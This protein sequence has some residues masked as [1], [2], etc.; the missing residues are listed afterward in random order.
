MPIIEFNHNKYES[1]EGETV[2]EAL[3][4]QGIPIP[5]G[6]KS[7]ICQGCLMRYDNY[8]PTPVEQNGLSAS[9]RQKN[10]FLSCQCKPKN[11]IQ[12]YEP[13]ESEANQFK[14]VLVDKTLLND[15]VMRLR[16]QANLDYIPGQYVTLWKA[17]DA[18]RNYS[19]ASH[20]DYE[21]LLE[22]HI[23]RISNGAVSYWVFDELETGQSIKFSGP[24]GT[25]VYPVNI[26]EDQHQIKPMLMIAM[27][28]GLA[29]I[30]GVLKDALKHQHNKPI[31]LVVGTTHSNGFYYVDEIHELIKSHSNVKSHFIS[32]EGNSNY[33]TQGNIYDFCK[34]NFPDLKNHWIFVCGKA[35]FVQ[36]MKKQCFLSGAQLSDIYADAFL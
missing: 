34:Q 5:H 29:P 28:T 36:K 12:V 20:P 32:L 16:I 19:L 15:S 27:G 24:I 7:G 30:L 1:L 22:F 11:N 25:C 13:S 35:S 2:L 31:H 10:L 9:Q 3:L 23:K 6:C 14:G 18:I 33:S 4:R 8:T 17:P 26:S 21:Q